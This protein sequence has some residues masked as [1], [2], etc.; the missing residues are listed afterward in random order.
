MA[1]RSRFAGHAAEL[2]LAYAPI[3]DLTKA[4]SR[5]RARASPTPW[6]PSAQPSSRQVERVRLFDLIRDAVSQALRGP[7]PGLLLV[8]DAHWL[9]PTS[10]DL[11][12][13][14]LRRPPPGVL[15]LATLRERGLRELAP[16]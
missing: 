13:Y 3:L 6:R 8:D 16:R 7:S 10:A 11:L 4:L 14:L 1:Q 2:G 9:D 5:T 15:V 12:G